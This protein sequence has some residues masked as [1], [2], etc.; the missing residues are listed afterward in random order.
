MA[1][2]RQAVGIYRG[3][4]MLSYKQETDFLRG[5]AAAWARILAYIQHKYDG[6]GA[7]LKE[8]LVKGELGPWSIGSHMMGETI[9]KESNLCGTLDAKQ[10]DDCGVCLY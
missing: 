4:G 1:G 3:S 2:I 8:N 7:G 6:V 5:Y 10:K 9:P